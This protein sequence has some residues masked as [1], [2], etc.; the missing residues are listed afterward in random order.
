MLLIFGENI[1]API[2]QNTLKVSNTIR[3]RGMTK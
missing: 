2:L 1:T 3:F